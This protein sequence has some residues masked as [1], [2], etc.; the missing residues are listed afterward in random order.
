MENKKIIKNQLELDD[1]FKEEAQKE[2]ANMIKNL[3]VRKHAD[4]MEVQLD[5]DA[6]FDEETNEILTLRDLLKSEKDVDCKTMDMK[7]KAEI[8]SNRLKIQKDFLINIIN[9]GF[10]HQKRALKEVQKRSKLGI[11]IIESECKLITRVLEEAKRRIQKG[12]LQL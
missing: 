9:I 2:I 10:I 1:E 11:Y 7:I 6:G 8:V 4:N 12:V 3:K 5:M